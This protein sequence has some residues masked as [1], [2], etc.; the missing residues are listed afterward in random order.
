MLPIGQTRACLSGFHC[1]SPRGTEIFIFAL[2]M[3]PKKEGYGGLRV[4]YSTDL[5]NLVSTCQTNTLQ[6]D[7][8]RLS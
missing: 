7:F 6:N 8:E 3:Q 1:H 5:L 4:L 2:G